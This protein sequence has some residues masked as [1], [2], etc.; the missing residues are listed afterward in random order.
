MRGGRCKVR[1]GLYQAAIAA[2]RCCPTR[3]AFDAALKARGQASKGA[4]VAVARQLLVLANALV[5]DNRTYEP[6]RAN[7]VC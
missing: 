5:R 3:K 7:S 2:I 6:A 1:S 4:I